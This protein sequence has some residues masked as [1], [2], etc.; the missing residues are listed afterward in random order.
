MKVCGKCQ[1]LR[2]EADF[3]R[4]GKIRQAWCR[5][6]RK[7]YDAAYHAKY[8]ERRRELRRLKA[9][10]FKKWYWELKESLPC[11]DCG[12]Y[13]RHPAMTWDHLPG[14]EKRADVG[15]LT[16]YSSRNVVL[17]EIAKCE[18]VCA[19]CHAVRTFERG[20]G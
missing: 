3:H 13:F 6:C 9:I 5:E 15:F 1:K 12:S 10:E 16:R 18:L 17:K 4:R 11:T 14:F 7:A 20:R 8:R 2:P 19:N